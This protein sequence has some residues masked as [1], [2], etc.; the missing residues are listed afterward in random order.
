M[1]ATSILFANTTGVAQPSG[2]TCVFAIHGLG[3][4]RTD[5]AVER[6]LK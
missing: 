5:R 3:S 6:Y 1:N 2:S 4:A